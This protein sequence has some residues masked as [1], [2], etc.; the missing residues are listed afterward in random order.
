MTAAGTP[1]AAEAP[2]AARRAPAGS[3]DGEPR[4]SMP[5]RSARDPGSYRDPAGFVYRRSGI[6]YRQV[7]ASFA[8]DWDCLPRLRPLRAPAGGRAHPRP[9]GGRPRRWRR[10]RRPTA[11]SGRSA[12]DFVS[13]PYEW[14]FSQLKDAALLTLRAQSLAAEAGMTLRDAS[15]YNVQFQRG[16][17]GAHRLALLRAGRS[18]VGPGSPT[19]SSASTSWPRWRSWH[20]STSDSAGSCAT[21][22]RACRSTLRLACCPSRT[23]FSLGLGPHIHLHARAQRQHADDHRDGADAADGTAHGQHVLVT[24]GH[25]RGVA[26]HHD[27]GARLGP[28]G[29]R[30]GRLRGEHQLRRCGHGSQGVGR[31]VRS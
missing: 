15:A 21:T 8:E 6:V 25:A 30:L 26:A 19:V 18:R 28:R 7:Q 16:P 4:G 1:E 11:S 10:R 23:R 22:S 12:C 17:S 31:G 9:R 14:S 5:E 13:Y 3:R 20:G 29:D 24:P 2:P 27:R